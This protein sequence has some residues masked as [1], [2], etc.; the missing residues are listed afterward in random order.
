MPSDV[1][2][3]V[4]HLRDHALDDLIRRRTLPVVGVDMQSDRQIAHAL[5]NL[6]G[7]DLVGGS[8]LGVAEI[9]RPE[10]L[11][12]SA[13]KRFEQALGRVDFQRDE[14]VRQF[15][16]IGMSKGVVANVVTLGEKALD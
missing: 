10:Q 7:H 15:P 11:H 12:G 16:E 2:I 3:G 4:G 1:G 13:R 8:G 6:D 14:R 5:R 9:G